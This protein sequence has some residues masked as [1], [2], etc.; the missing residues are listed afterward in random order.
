MLRVDVRTIR[1]GSTPIE[2]SVPADD[3]AFVG[4]GVNLTAP[5]RVTGLLQAAGEGTYRLAGR[6]E[7][8]AKGECRRCL[9][10]LSLPFDVQF[11]AVFTTSQDMLDDP[12]VYQLS[13]PVTQIDLSEAIREEVG[14][15]VPTYALCRE[16]CAGLCPR[17]GADL[18]EGP[19]GCGQAP[20]TT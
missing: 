5:V 2:V 13:E 3:P 16:E 1:Q 10:E 4:L 18:N 14:L 17:C 8:T 20:E 9:K 11:D 15:A 7:G 19:C 6:A 12:G